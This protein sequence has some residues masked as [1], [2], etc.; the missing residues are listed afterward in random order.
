M[1]APSTPR[2]QNYLRAAA[3]VFSLFFICAAIFISSSQAQSSGSKQNSTFTARLINIESAV[4]TPFRYNTSLYNGSGQTNIYEL[5]VKAP[6]GWMTSFRTDGSQVAAV[7]VEAGK[8][9]NIS[10][11]ITASPSAK[12]GKYDIPVSAVTN[13][14]TLRIDLEAVVKGSYDL[15]L[16]TPTGRLSDDI[17]EGSSKQLQLTVKNTGTLPL[18]DVALSA[19]SPTQ[20]STKFE[21]SNIERL[22]PGQ[23]QEVEASLSVPDKTIA[24]DY[25]T[26]FTAKNSFATADAAFRMTVKTSLLSGWI[27]IMVI[28]LALATVYYL[29]RKYGRR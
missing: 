20:W 4:T 19:Q 15:Q 2:R 28:L 22:D 23:S 5:L 11:E 1:L 17:T 25:V 6:D 10:V 24:G 13:G 9:Q 14:D 21:P 7:R 3:Y 27:G 26:N 18:N 12:P 16:T 29:V 8:T